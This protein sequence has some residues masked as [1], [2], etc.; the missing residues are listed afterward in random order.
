MK[1]EIVVVEKV[2][3]A[4]LA[5]SAMSVN[6]LKE[7]FASC[8][9]SPDTIRKRILIRNRRHS[10]VKLNCLLWYCVS[11]RCRRL[12]NGDTNITIE[13]RPPSLDIIEYLL[14][15]HGPNDTG[16]NTTSYKGMSFLTYCI[17]KFG[18]AQYHLISTLLTHGADPSPGLLPNGTLYPLLAAV[19]VANS[20]ELA[21]L[22][23]EA[24]ADVNGYSNII[25]GNH[26]L[27][28]CRA[29]TE[30]IDD[31]IIDYRTICQLN[32]LVPLASIH[33]GEPTACDFVQLLGSH[34]ADMNPTLVFPNI[35]KVCNIKV[36][37][38]A[39][40]EGA[41]HK[42][43]LALADLGTDMVSMGDYAEALPAD[44]IASSSHLILQ[45][46][47]IV[48]SPF[49]AM[50]L[51]HLGTGT[52]PSKESLAF[53]LETHGV[54]VNIPIPYDGAT[55]LHIAAMLMES[56]G[57]I[58]A[59]NYYAMEFYIMYLLQHGADPYACNK[60]SRSPLDCIY[61]QAMRDA[62]I[63]IL[64]KWSQDGGKTLKA[65][66][67]DSAAAAATTDVEWDVTR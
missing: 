4:R 62:L 7:V 29:S 67:K 30:S 27:N 56:I 53:Y 54:D 28:R 61:N 36:A 51:R 17:C 31:A 58:T 9:R 26:R 35:D 22:L 20:V 45:P 10:Q 39:E 15:A 60:Y 42:C 13:I 6:R 66:A 14:A 43:M 59:N 12:K 49:H 52:I 47:S 48:K 24:G 21:R 3:A 63:S 16:V 23:L 46:I 41:T 2:N 50:L 11:K 64:C 37:V 55:P 32:P 8:R 44:D 57:D 19:Y 1:E 40:S 65:A 25:T 34:G 38:K 33:F 5:C 18:Q